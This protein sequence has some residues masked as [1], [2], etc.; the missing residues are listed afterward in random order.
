[1]T[2]RNGVHGATA[3]ATAG[4]IG[5]A[6]LGGCAASSGGGGGGEPMSHPQAVRIAERGLAAEG[7]LT[8]LIRG[9]DQ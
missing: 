3:A 5:M 6:L 9:L 4:A 2:K 7:A 8:E 1:M